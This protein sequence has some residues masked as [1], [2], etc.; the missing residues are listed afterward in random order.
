M[1]VLP[2]FGAGSAE[3][4]SCDSGRAIAEMPAAVLQGHHLHAHGNTDL[5]ARLVRLLLPPLS[6]FAEWALLTS[7]L[8]SGTRPACP[9][10]ANDA[11]A[12][13]RTETNTTDSSC[14]ARETTQASRTT[15]RE[16]AGK[17]RD[18]GALRMRR[19][20]LAD[21]DASTYASMRVETLTT[22]CDCPSCVQPRV[23][24]LQIYVLWFTSSEQYHL[25]PAT[26]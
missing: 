15:R 16:E 26:L 20:L 6:R 5:H 9:P 19:P 18:S 8:W 10:H 3:A 21:T 25:Q 1:A 13:T 23:C 7:V 11:S 17:A 14:R 4:E 12:D 22:P 24:K 2:L